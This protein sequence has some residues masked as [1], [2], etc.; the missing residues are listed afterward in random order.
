MPVAALAFSG[1]LDTSYA[2]LALRREGH[3]VVTVTA[4]SGGFSPAELRSIEDRARAL[5]VRS[6][7]TVDGR[8][9]VYHR[10]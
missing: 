9:E 10:F 1:G 7:T 3:D 4:D 8:A 5:G 2:V 6:H